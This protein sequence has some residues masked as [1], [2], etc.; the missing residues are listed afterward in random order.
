MYHLIPDQ[1]TGLHKQ[2]ASGNKI[3]IKVQLTKN[4]HIQLIPLYPEEVLLPVLS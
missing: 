2:K 4:S 1:L 3:K